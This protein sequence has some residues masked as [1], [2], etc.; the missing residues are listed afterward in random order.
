MTNTYKRHS[1]GFFGR[2]LRSIISV[3]ILS[4]LVLGIS[5]SVKQLSTLNS[6]K[7]VNMSMNLASRFGMDNSKIGEV[8]GALIDRS[9]SVTINDT[10]TSTESHKT[11]SKE[12][13]FAVIAD[14]HD[15]IPNL[16]KALDMAKKEN[17]Q[18]VFF[19]GDYTN[20][21]DKDSLQKMKSTMDASGLTYYS[22]PG[23]H[24]LAASVQAGDTAGLTNYK[25]VFGD[26]YHSITLK[27][28]KVVMLDNS[29][30]YTT[31]S[32]TLINWFKSEVINADFV[33]LSQPLYHPTINL[34]M[35]VVHGNTVPDVKA[36][37]EELLSYIRTSSVKAII[38][39]D[40]HN[41]SENTDPKKS[42]LQHIVT[43]AVVGNDIELQNPQKPR[44]TL[45]DIN[46]DGSY[47]V[48]DTPLE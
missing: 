37:A 2:L 6:K 26:N 14:S 40:Q 17:A 46:N 23:D 28:K 21:G 32:S 16:T 39:G 9:N 25:Q 45:I 27:G 7:V 13:T 47:T 33:M 41:F 29:A 4:T 5:Y 20:W 11:I 35:G 1:P 22:I 18:A 12:F 3:F 48:R 31:V 36:Q 44:F 42:T 15:D 24:D 8:A 34:V 30:N 19:L 10:P 38:A 43:G